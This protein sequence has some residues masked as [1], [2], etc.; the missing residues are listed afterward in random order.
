[1]EQKKAKNREQD[2]FQA[3]ELQK[4]LNRIKGVALIPKENNEE[5]K[6]DFA[7]MILYFD[8]ATYR[9]FKDYNINKHIVSLLDNKFPI[10]SMNMQENNI[11]A[12]FSITD[13]NSGMVFKL[14]DQP[15]SKPLLN[16]LQLSN[17]YDKIVMMI[18]CDNIEL[19]NKDLHENVLLILDGYFP[20]P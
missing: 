4:Y 16:F 17:Y 3:K 6:E 19:N 20:E 12:S 7:I 11:M 2:S 15:M 9:E 18:G 14:P 10:L 5:T 1:M 13:E 8:E